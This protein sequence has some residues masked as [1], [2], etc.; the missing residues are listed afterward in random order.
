ME[1]AV[2]MFLDWVMRIFK[3][4]IVVFAI[5]L[6][7]IVFTSV[8]FRYFLDASIAWASE[9]SRFLFIWLSFMGIV[10]AYSSNEHMKFDFLVTKMPKITG[11]LVRIV[12]YL[13]ILL[14]VAVLTRGGAIIVKED[15]TWLAPP[16]E[17][18][19]GLAYLIAPL[20]TIILIVQTVMRIYVTAKSLFTQ[21]SKG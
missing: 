21:S 12:V 16:M 5:A 18:P 10:V 11:N 14:I 7:G 4:L 8:I 9:A 3:F 2:S 19:Y 17:I 6:V 1:A 15:W 20:S 13:I